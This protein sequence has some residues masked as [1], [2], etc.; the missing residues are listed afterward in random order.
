M[1]NNH[2]NNILWTASDMPLPKDLWSRLEDMGYRV[3]MGDG[4]NNTL[5]KIHKV[6]PKLWVD[7]I[8]GEPDGHFS[9]LE[10][11]VTK[12]PELPIVLL[13]SQPTIDEAV[14][15]IKLG[16][17]D[18]LPGVVTPEKLWVTLEGAL[19]YPRVTKRPQRQVSAKPSKQN[20]PIAIHPSMQQL[21][22]VAKRI[23]PSRSN[24]LIQGE[25]GTGK[26]VLARYIHQCSDRASGPFI[27]VNCAALPETLLESELFGH[28]RGAFT[29]AVAKKKGK[30]ELA[31]GG[32][33]L[34]DEISEIPLSMQAKL[35]RVL[36]EREIDRVGGQ[37]TVP[38]DARIIATTNRELDAETKNGNFRLDLFYRLNVVPLKLP[39]LRERKDDIVALSEYFLKTHCAL[40]QVESKKLTKDGVI[41]LKQKGWPGNV[42]EL[43]NLMERATLLIESQD[44]KAKDLEAISIPEGNGGELISDEQGVLPL[45]EMEKRMIFRALNDN[46]GNR[47]HAAK[48]LGIS[49]RTLRNKLQEY[50][51]EIDKEDAPPHL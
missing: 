29:G 9:A 11:V 15:A 24:V 37:F 14:K 19:N 16:I 26:E 35:L 1:G 36:Q 25:S 4:G 39:S 38:V 46:Q 40:N 33:L 49:V 47:T 17:S 41:Y 20:E 44:I 23:A 5:D 31:N 10:Q 2:H 18:Y 48:N 3:L 34:L 45:R 50:R 6:S 27:A 13:S 22:A 51:K 30:F 12:F 42:R 32:S 21:L 28:E 43:E 8:N 7:Q